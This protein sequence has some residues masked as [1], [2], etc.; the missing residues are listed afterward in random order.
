[1]LLR[2]SGRRWMRDGDAERGGGGGS[3]QAQGCRLMVAW[4]T[5]AQERDEQRHEDLWQS[6]QRDETARGPLV[7]IAA[8]S[9]G[10]LPIDLRF[11]LRDSA[12]RMR[13]NGGN[14]H[15]IS[16]I[17]THTHTRS[18]H[19]GDVT[20]RL[21]LAQHESNHEQPADERRQRHEYGDE[22]QINPN[23]V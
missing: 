19:L 5:R 11:Y 18:R 15:V 9:V 8:P 16:A 6:N 3:W 1:M 13:A 21:P 12:T 22:H 7:Q 23:H 10:H 17:F 4:R 14:V 2:A 20:D